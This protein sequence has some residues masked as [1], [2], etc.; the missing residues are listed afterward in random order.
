MTEEVLAIS[1]TAIFSKSFKVKTK[2]IYTYA[3]HMTTA[4]LPQRLF[5]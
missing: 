4:E 5:L 1:E 3:T 2:T